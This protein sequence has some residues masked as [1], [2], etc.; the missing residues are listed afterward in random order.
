MMTEDVSDKIYDSIK[1]CAHANY[2]MLRIWGGGCYG[3]DYFYDC[4]DKYG[5]LVWQDVMIACAHICLDDSLEK[6]IMAEVEENL[7]RIRNHA[8]LALICG[9]NEMEPYCS[10][11]F[12]SIMI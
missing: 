10:G 4:C 12:R 11:C 1:E 5:I 8:S 9:N 2:N 6:S 7:Q 3:S